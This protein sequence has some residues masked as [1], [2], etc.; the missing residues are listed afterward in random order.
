MVPSH[1]IAAIMGSGKEL[2]LQL[3]GRVHKCQLDC[4]NLSPYMYANCRGEWEAGVHGSR[5]ACRTT[6]NHSMS[7]GEPCESGRDSPLDV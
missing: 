1:G 7:S 2:F 4:V 6:Y 5:G 3:L